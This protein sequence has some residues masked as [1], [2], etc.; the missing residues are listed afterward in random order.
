MAQCLHEGETRAALLRKKG[1]V[2]RCAVPRRAFYPE[3]QSEGTRLRSV[4]SG[5]AFIRGALHPG[6]TCIAFMGFAQGTEREE[7]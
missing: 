6:T 1:S 4:K 3:F 7:R 2:L 5:K